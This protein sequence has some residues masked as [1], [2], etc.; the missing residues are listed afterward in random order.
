MFVDQVFCITPKGTLV[1]LPKGASAIDFA[2]AIHSEVGNHAVGAKI[3]GKPSP[4]KTIVE[5]GDQ[6]DI[7][8]DQRH[9]PKPSWENYAI[10]IKAKSSI[11]K[12]LNIMEKER[13]EMIG[14]TNFEEFFKR[15]NLDIADSEIQRIASYLKVENQVNL[16]HSIGS[17]S[18]NIREVFAAYNSLNQA[19]PLKFPE[20][21]Y[22]THSKTCETVLISG[23]PD[24]P[25]LPVSCCTPVPGDKIIGLVFKD[26]GIEIH[27][28]NCKILKDQE[29]NSGAQSVVLSWQNSAFNTNIRH[30]TKISITIICAPG[31]LAKISDIIEQKE[32]NIINLKIGE[33][34]ENFVQLQIEVEV[35]DVSQLT[36]LIAAIR[37]ASFVHSVDRV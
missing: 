10:T 29:I 24:V 28:E 31:N 18:I 37:S 11:K 16:F 23:I 4:L 15:H 26:K 19:R 3:N 5:N 8:T 36:M 14:K 1:S 27:L 13:I 12:A 35:F 22:K 17:G 20:E 34:F 2:Y 25:I 9:M 30:I 21:E 6:I 7:I 33:K 32:A